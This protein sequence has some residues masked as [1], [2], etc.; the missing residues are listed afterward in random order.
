MIKIISYIVVAFFY[1][2]KNILHKG[3]YYSTGSCGILRDPAGTKAC[4][5]AADFID[6][7]EKIHDFIR[8]LS[9]DI[10]ISVLSQCRI[11]VAVHSM[12]HRCSFFNSN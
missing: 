7:D 1:R 4:V 2:K 12:K 10:K 8:P 5:M 6:S 3:I 9:C 11:L